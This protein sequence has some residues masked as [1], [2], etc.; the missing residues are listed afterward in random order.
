MGV[1]S[2]RRSK[3]SRGSDRG[4]LRGRS[5]FTGR[6]P[7]KH[8]VRGGDSSKWRS[9]AGSPGRVPGGSRRPVR[10]VG[11]HGQVSSFRNV[12][13]GDGVTFVY[14]G[15]GYGADGGVACAPQ[16]HADSYVVE[17]DPRIVAQLQMAFGK[18]TL[19]VGYQTDGHECVTSADLEAA[20]GSGG[21]L[22][23]GE[24]LPSGV[25]KLLDDE[26]L[27]ASTATSLYDLG[28]GTGKMALQA[29]LMYDNLKTV[30]GV[31][32]SPSRYTIGETALRR[33]VACCPSRFIIASWTRGHEIVMAAGDRRLVFRRGNLFEEPDVVAA[34]I[35]VLETDLPP[36]VHP[37]VCHLISR[38]RAG[39]R[40][41]TYLNIRN[42]WTLPVF[43]LR[44]MAANRSSNDRFLT[45]W[46]FTHGHRF[47]L[48][49]ML[50]NDPEIAAEVISRQRERERER[51]REV[52]RRQ[53]DA[54][55]QLNSS[56]GVGGDALVVERPHPHAIPLVSNDDNAGDAP[57]MEPPA[58]VSS[59]SVS[60][61]SASTGSPAV[62]PMAATPVVRDDAEAQRVA[63]AALAAVAGEAQGGEGVGNE[64]LPVGVDVDVQELGVDAAAVSTATAVLDEARVIAEAAARDSELVGGMSGGM[65]RARH[66]LSGADDESVSTAGVSSD[67]VSGDARGASVSVVSPLAVGSSRSSSTSVHSDDDDDG[68]GDDEEIAGG[69]RARGLRSRWSAGHNAGDSNSRNR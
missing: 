23:Y 34:D 24:V 58:T 27:S 30:V 17:C 46:S 9:K 5:G 66:T 35:V 28:M 65:E 48:W 7:S 44:R 16:Y 14:G 8:A 31:E 13:H 43:P 67:G 49:H 10:C 3:A 57:G 18:S 50:G 38:L 60:S 41:L 64:P 36:V 56:N 29:F 37:Q 69:P 45:S 51:R 68:S 15:D 20:Q 53:G 6:G 54:S 33:F 40:L 52:D 59:A 63:A 32:L 47:F 21:S 61:A 12:H 4:H 11:G 55:W 22:L 39:T 62:L 1:G 26:H 2:S 25:C 42:L 19:E